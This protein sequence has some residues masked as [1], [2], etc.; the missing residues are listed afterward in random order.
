M[1]TISKAFDVSPIDAKLPFGAIVHGLRHD[2]LRDPDVRQALVDLWI[3]K[4]VLLFRDGDATGAMQL[5]LSRCFG[6]L[7]AHLFPESR[8]EDVPELT[9]I[10]F[11]PEDGSYYSI[12]GELR[13]GWL[14]WHSD[15]TYTN[16]INRGGILRPVQ[17]PRRL[18]MTGFLCQIAAWNRLPV[19]LQEKIEGL[20]VVYEVEVNM[21]LQ[22]YSGVDARLVRL[23]RSG[24][25]IEKRKYGYPRVIHP[26]VYVQ[27]ETGRKIL[28]VSPAF[29]VGIY[30][31]GSPAGDALLAEVMAYCTDN[32][33]AYFHDWKRDDMV[34]WD[35]WRTLH[36]ATGVEPDE[37]RVMVRTTIAG[38]YALGRNLGAGGPQVDFDV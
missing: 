24:T 1:A 35:N 5:D 9:K 20:H 7:E 12:N 19:V 31:N 25:T 10:K 32:A 37:T 22:R 13:G 4:G 2:A 38:D 15:L 16:R 27:Q 8:S 23:A 29:A 30:E 17:L 26:M 3:D 11:Y 34:L 33:L 21:E 6:P 28:N 36:C 14:P 18:G